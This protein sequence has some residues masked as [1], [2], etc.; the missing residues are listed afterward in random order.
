VRPP[1][2][3]QQ[4]LFN[5]PTVVNNVETLANL[6][7]IIQ[8]GG[9]AY[10]AIGAAKSSGTKLVSLDSFFNRP[11]IYEVDMGTPLSI[12]INEL[13]QGFKS[14]IKA[15]HIGGP[16][17]GLVP[18]HKINDLSIDFD[19][20]AANGFLLGHAS[21]VCIP[22]AFPIIDYLRHLFQFT[23]H[24]SCGKCFPCRLGSTRGAE[25]L[26]K[27]IDEQYKIDKKLF[28][29]LLQTMEI[30]SLCALGGGLPLPV[31]NALQYFNNELQTYFK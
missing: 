12:V 15:M 23:A 29:D 11:G 21:F 20:F 18:V 26:S 31:K 8:N 30:G 22:Q 28:N 7:F 9:N 17:G 25:M 10:A 24:E 14:E 4:G 6:P 3:T 2:P 1:Y 19:S 16:L 27:A 13:G 5:K